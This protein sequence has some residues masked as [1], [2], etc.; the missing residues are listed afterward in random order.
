LNSLLTFA[1]PELSLLYDNA[2]SVSKAVFLF[3]AASGG[4]LTHRFQ[5]LLKFIVL[6]VYG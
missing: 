3:L 1:S 5:D 4:R 2:D 6:D